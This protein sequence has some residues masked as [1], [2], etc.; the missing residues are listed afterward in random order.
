MKSEKGCEWEKA[1]HEVN[2]WQ[3]N[4]KNP[5]ENT[6]YFQGNFILRNLKICE[7]Y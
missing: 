4:F 3:K 2:M 1:C 5:Y 6:F 7:C